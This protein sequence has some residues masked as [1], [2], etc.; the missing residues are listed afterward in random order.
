MTKFNDMIKQALEKKQGK[1]NL[2]RGEQPDVDI[3]SKKPVTPTVSG[4]PVKKST[5]R[6]R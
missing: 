3:K 5:G 6:G 2:E 1:Q 4:K